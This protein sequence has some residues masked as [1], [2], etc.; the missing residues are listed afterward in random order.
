MKEDMKR[1]GVMLAYG[2]MIHCGNPQTEKVK[3]KQ[4]KKNV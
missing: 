1:V 2:K 3:E 4:I